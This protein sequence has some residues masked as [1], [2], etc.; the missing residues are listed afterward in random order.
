M[1]AQHMHANSYRQDP[2]GWP[3]DEALRLPRQMALVTFTHRDGSEFHYY[4]RECLAESTR[5][6]ILAMGGTIRF[7]DVESFVSLRT[8]P[9]EE[10]GA[11]LYG[12]PQAT[13]PQSFLRSIGVAAWTF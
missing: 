5:Q 11:R 1:M 4:H 2:F 10:C 12:P 7:L 3:G 13:P 6:D 9:C 8:A